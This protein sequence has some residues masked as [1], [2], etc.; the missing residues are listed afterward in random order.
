GANDGGECLKQPEH[1]FPL[2]CT[3]PIQSQE[4]T[5]IIGKYTVNSADPS[6]LNQCKSVQLGFTEPS[7]QT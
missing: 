2:D 7:A 6:L 4:V 1:T 3:Q 5:Y